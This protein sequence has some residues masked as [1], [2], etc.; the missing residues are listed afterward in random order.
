MTGALIKMSTITEIDFSILDYIHNNWS[1]G[2]LDFI[3][4]QITFLGNVGMIWILAAALMFIC[5]KYRKNGI[6]LAISLGCC[7]FIGNLLLKNLVA[8]LRPCWINESVNM[9]ISVPMILAD[10]VLTALM[11][12]GI[13]VFDY[14]IP[15]ESVYA[16]VNP[17]AGLELS[18][19]LSGSPNSL[20]ATSNSC[21]PTDWRNKFSDKFSDTVIS[22]ENNYKSPNLSIELT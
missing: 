13:W 3:M 10:I 14:C 19:M 9:L 21:A 6:M 17:T 5:K 2:F 8:R 16:P 1:N 18:G 22:T 11:V 15:Q 7:F 4:P 12:L 20:N